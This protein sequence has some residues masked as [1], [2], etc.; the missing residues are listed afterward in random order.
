MNNFDLWKWTTGNRAQTQTSYSKKKWWYVLAMLG[1]F[2]G[3]ML[4]Y[5]LISVMW[6]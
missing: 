1:V 5:Y 4:L 6:Q 2:V 3:M